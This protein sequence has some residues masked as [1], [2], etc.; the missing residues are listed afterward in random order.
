V[1]AKTLMTLSPHFHAHSFVS[2]LIFLFLH[3]NA[4]LLGESCIRNTQR[5]SRNTGKNSTSTI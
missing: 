4:V 3:R 5:Y 1:I 2:L